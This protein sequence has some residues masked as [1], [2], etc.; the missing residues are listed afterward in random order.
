MLKVLIVMLK[1][2]SMDGTS[3]LAVATFVQT[4]K[5]DKQVARVKL[6]ILGILL[7]ANVNSVQKMIN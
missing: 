1:L 3:T 6:I 5:L 7:N 4:V 2:L